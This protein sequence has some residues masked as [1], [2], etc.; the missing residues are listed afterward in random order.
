MCRKLTGIYPKGA[1]GKKC[2]CMDYPFFHIFAALSSSLD[3]EQGPLWVIAQ[4]PV[5]AIAPHK[6]T[7][8]FEHIHIAA[9][10]MT[11]AP[12]RADGSLLESTVLHLITPG[13]LGE[14]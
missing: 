11:M 7:L 10:E 9:M 14:F 2:E 3:F 12:T 8:T 6:M 13:L 5:P 1:P 4:T